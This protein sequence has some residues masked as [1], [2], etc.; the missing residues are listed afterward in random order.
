MSSW[1]EFGLL[2]LGLCLSLAIAWWRYYR[3]NR[4]DL[5]MWRK[6]TLRFGLVGNTVSLVLCLADLVRL[7]LIMRGIVR[8]LGPGWAY[9]WGLTA[10]LA[11][12]LASTV[13][14]GFG[15]GAARVLTIVCGV[16]LTIV[17][18]FL[19]LSTIP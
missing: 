10:L 8:H 15:R 3:M 18:F 17:W 2:I 4:L 16:L 1:I 9:T 19:A 7:Q 13:C 5:R 11:L 14:A 6:R 12:V